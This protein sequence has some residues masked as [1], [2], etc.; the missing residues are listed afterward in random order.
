MMTVTY[1]NDKVLFALMTHVSLSQENQNQTLE[2][3]VSK[4]INRQIC[5]WIIAVIKIKKILREIV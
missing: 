4:H 2:E 3:E 5:L 1:E